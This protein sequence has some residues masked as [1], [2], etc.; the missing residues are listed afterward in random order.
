MRV[1]LIIF[2]VYFICLCTSDAVLRTCSMHEPEA[3]IGY[4]DWPSAT[5]GGSAQSA[6]GSVSSS[7]YKSAIVSS[8]TR[9]TRHQHLQPSYVSVSSV[10]FSDS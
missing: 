1:H 9:P 2:N 3:D 4:S 6:S 5:A 10:Q 8:A 7:Y